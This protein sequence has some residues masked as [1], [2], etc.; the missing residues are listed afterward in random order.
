[1]ILCSMICVRVL[2]YLGFDNLEFSSRHVH[3]KRQTEFDRR[4]KDEMRESPSF[5]RHLPGSIILAQAGSRE[6]R[7]AKICLVAGISPTL[8]TLSGCVGHPQMLI[9]PL[10]GLVTPGAMSSSFAKPAGFVG[11]TCRMIFSNYPANHAIHDETSLWRKTS[12]HKGG[13]D[14]NLAHHI[15]M[16]CSERRAVF[17]TPFSPTFP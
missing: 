9:G 10:I 4:E 7:G 12:E 8:A 15:A 1:M 2:V 3:I 11:H 16:H 6:M 14:R 5:L 13:C 17:V